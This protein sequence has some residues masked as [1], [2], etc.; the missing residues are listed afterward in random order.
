M[1]LAR[2]LCK[3]HTNLRSN[4][5]FNDSLVTKQFSRVIS[6]DSGKLR[7]EFWQQIFAKSLYQLNDFCFSK[8]KGTAKPKQTE[9]AEEALSN[10]EKYFQSRLAAVNELKQQTGADPYPHKFH[11][12]RTIPAYRNEYDHI[13]NGGKLDN[14]SESV[15]G[16]IYSIR[17]A[18]KLVFVDLRGDGMKLQVKIY[19]ASFATPDEFNL[20]VNTLRR[21]DIIGVEGTPS[22]TKRGELSIDA[23]K[24]SSP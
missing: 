18:N 10:P 3:F 24:V 11:V 2:R 21:G 16:R 15:A 20:F 12:S 9:N 1:N 23:K 7:L 22:R 13:K 14:V 19:E 5:I 17:N 6:S 4:T 8:V